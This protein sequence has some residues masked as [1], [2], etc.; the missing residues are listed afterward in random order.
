MVASSGLKPEQNGFNDERDRMSVIRMQ[1]H[2]KNEPSGFTLIELLVVIAIIALLLSVMLPSLRK[3]KEYAKRLVCTSN[4][5][6]IAVAAIAYMGDNNGRFMYQHAKNAYAIP[7]AL[8][9]GQPNWISRVWPYI[10]GQ[11]KAFRCPSN[12][13]RKDDVNNQFYPTEE[14]TFS[15]VANGVITHLGRVQRTPPATL[16]AFFDDYDDGN[17]AVLRP[18]YE[19]VIEPGG[20]IPKGA[21]G[22]VGW[23]W[24]G[25]GTTKLTAMPHNGRVHAFL[26]GHADWDEEG[27]LTSRKYGLL[28][29]GEDTFEPGP[30][31]GDYRSTSRWGAMVVE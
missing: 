18:H 22:W 19:G 27:A 12:K 23:M 29:N 24:Y 10:D 20:R 14:E 7:N 2:K 17:G 26:D 28:I 25:N 6:G 11:K 9:S 3:A 5:H 15:Y 4:Q 16:V 31:A 1:Y 21:N 13:W 8:A 30:G